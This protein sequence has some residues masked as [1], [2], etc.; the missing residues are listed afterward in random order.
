RI[1][2]SISSH[3][4]EEGEGSEVA[5]IHFAVT[6]ALALLDWKRRSRRSTS[7]PMASQVTR[8]NPVVFIC[9]DTICC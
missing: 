1:A 6:V 5:F 9:G 4:L 3:M 2:D 8:S 7:S